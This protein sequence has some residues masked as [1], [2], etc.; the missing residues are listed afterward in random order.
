MLIEADGVHAEIDSS[1][2]PLHHQPH[3]SS[4]PLIQSTAEPSQ[5]EAEP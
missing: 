1:N 2:P 3:V 4:R 5:G